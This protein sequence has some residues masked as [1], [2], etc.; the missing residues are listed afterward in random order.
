[1]RMIFEGYMD[2]KQIDMTPK[3]QLIEYFR[4]FEGRPGFEEIDFS[5]LENSIEANDT[6]RVN[7]N[8]IL[9][10]ID[11]EYLQ[12]IEVASTIIHE[13]TH[14]NEMEEQGGT[15]EAGPEAAERAFA[16]AILS[17]SI[18]YNLLLDLKQ[19]NEWADQERNLY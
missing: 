6:I 5:N 2:S 9:S 4:Q 1:M 11:S 18:G 19:M 12:V 10:E 13:A 8:K 7:I 3:N 14:A 15:S 16:S 17:G